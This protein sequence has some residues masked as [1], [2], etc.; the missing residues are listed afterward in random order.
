MLNGR[1]WWTNPG[2]QFEY[3]ETTNDTETPLTKAATIVW[4]EMPTAELPDFLAA[5][6]RVMKIMIET[7]E[8]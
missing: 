6:E 2:V 3:Q 5:V 7:T 4:E 8:A 1:N